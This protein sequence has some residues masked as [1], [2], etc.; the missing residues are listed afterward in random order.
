M[1]CCKLQVDPTLYLCIKLKNLFTEEEKKK[2]EKK[3]LVEEI[4]L[5]L[6]ISKVLASEVETSY[7]F[8]ILLFLTQY[9]LKIQLLMDEYLCEF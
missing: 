2:K 8:S 5:L 6:S 7:Q 9:F 4:K 3:V 1:E